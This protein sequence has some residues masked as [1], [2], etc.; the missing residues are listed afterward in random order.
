MK[1]GDLVRRKGAKWLAV[2]TEVYSI[3]GK[4]HKVELIWVDEPPPN[5][6]PLVHGIRDSCSASLLEVVSEC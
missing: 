4:P 5:Y 1:R 2:I 6:D 3:L